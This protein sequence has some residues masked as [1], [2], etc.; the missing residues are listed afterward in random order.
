VQFIWNWNCEEI[1][2]SQ[3]SKILSIALPHL[4]IYFKTSTK[5]KGGFNMKTLTSSLVIFFASYSIL[6]AQPQFWHEQVSGTTAQLTS[7]S[8]VDHQVVWVCGYTGVVLRTTNSGVNWLNVSGG[9][10]P[11]TVSLINVWG[12]SATS[13]IVAGYQSTN[14]WV[15]KTTNAGVNWVQVFTQPNGFINVV[16][17][18]DGFPNQGIMQGDPVGGRW[19]LWKTTSTGTNWDSTG[20]YLPQSGTETGYNNSICYAGSKIWFGTNNTQIYYSNNDGATWVSRSTSPELNSY[21][22]LFSSQWNPSG[23]LGGATLMQSSDSGATWSTLTSLGTGNFG[24]FASLP[25]PV[26]AMFLDQIWYVRSSTSIYHSWSGGQGWFV[27]YTAPAGNY[28]HISKARGGTYIWAVR[29]NGGITRCTC[30]VSGISQISADVPET[31]SLKQNFPNPFNPQT[32]ID[33]DLPKRQNVKLNVYNINGELVTQLANN[34]FGAGSYRISWDASQYSS[35]VYFYSLITDGYVQT[36][37]MVL[38][39]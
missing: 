9:G 12:I 11:N 22:I 7:V 4:L 26:N 20:M 8:A 17:M 32:N 33:F 3:L 34:E 2:T 16:V 23:V 37:R 27:E 29:N 39:K 15:W 5:L 36:K 19:S 38:I 1:N 18:K 35:G 25:V 24:G 21:A 10:I 14:T 31:Y 28:R 30:F 6:F 13:A